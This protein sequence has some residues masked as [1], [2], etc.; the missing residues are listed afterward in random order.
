MS[1]DASVLLPVRDAE[2]TLEETLE[3]L[4]RQTYGRFEV[5]VHDDGST[6][7]SR[8][9]A[10]RYAE[11][12][13]RFLL[14]AA[15]PRGI[16]YALNHAATS[17]TSDLLVRMDADDVAHPERIEKLVAFGDLHAD[18]SFFASRIR[19]VPR[20]GL[21]DG[22]LR[23]ETWIYG[24]LS[25]AQI[26]RDRFVECPMPHPA[27]AIRRRAFEA[28]GGYRE[29]PFPEDY[30]LFL[31]AAQGGVRFG[32]VDQC[33]LDWRE[34]PDRMSRKDDRF[35]TSAFF[36]LKLDHLLPHLARG[37]RPVA[38]VGDK[39][40]VKRWTKALLDNGVLVR[41]APQDAYVLIAGGR[42]ETRSLWRERLAGEGLREETDFLA[43]Q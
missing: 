40:P 30:E 32:K 37:A 18:V 4:T 24:L 22:M 9:I 21:S 36:R 23:Y 3:S 35:A 15:E 16:V 43:V 6:H 31:R 25:H 33:L 12:D 38:V 26:H 8:E 28:L 19:Y 34:H 39:R 17:A 27:W 1:V 42:T 14:Q 2:A 11:R 13:P 5:I 29:G 41:E 20:E 7:G 10:A